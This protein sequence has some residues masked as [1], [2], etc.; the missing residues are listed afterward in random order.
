MNGHHCFQNRRVEKG[1]R[2]LRLGW[3]A[4]LGAGAVAAAAIAAGGSIGG[5]EPA[6][7]DEILETIRKREGQPAM[8]AAVFDSASLLASGAVGLRRLGGSERVGIADRWHIGSCTK[9]MT[10]LAIAGLVGEGKLSWSLTL[11]EGFASWKDGIHS[12]YRGATLEQIL[13]HRAGLP[14]WTQALPANERF[15]AGLNGSARSQRLAFARHVL[16]AGPETKPGAGVQYSNAGY[17]IAAC[18]AEEA[19]GVEWEDLLR[20]RVFEPLGLESAG[21]GW[22][23]T[24]A[25]PDQPWGHRAGAFGFGLVPMAAD[26][27]YRLAT[28]L[29]PAGD[30]HLSIEDFARY[31]RF[32]LACLRGRESPVAS[33]D[34]KLVRRLHRRDGEGAGA[35]GWLPLPIAG[36]PASWHNGSLGTFFAWM[37]LWPERDLG[38]VVAVNSGKGEAACQKATEDLFR[39][40][41]SRKGSGA[42]GAKVPGTPKKE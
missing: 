37:A 20:R 35:M 27:P 12:D 14:P 13:T 41:A 29:A 22:P 1:K 38:I 17:A 31:A 24:A 23:L 15:L 16:A 26:D 5:A 4:V 18:L 9:S 34:A 3:L 32:H 42:D 36:E 19:G 30:V 33:I 11:A 10:A 8:A 6:S 21:F 40:F 28:C 7:L 39:T 25:R 2:P